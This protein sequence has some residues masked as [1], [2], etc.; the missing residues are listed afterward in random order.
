MA[1]SCV[2]A[3]SLEAA[4]SIARGSIYDCVKHL[5]VSCIVNVLCCAVYVSAVICDVLIVNDLITPKND[6]SLI[7]PFMTTMERIKN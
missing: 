2:T 7:T 4:V 6:P 1:A 5:L 3:S